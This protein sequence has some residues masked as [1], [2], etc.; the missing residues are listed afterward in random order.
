MKFNSREKKPKI[1]NIAVLS[2]IAV[3]VIAVLICQDSQENALKIAIILDIYY[4]AVVVLLIRAFVLQL[5]YNPYSYNSIYYMGFSFF[6]FSSFITHIYLT[7]QLSSP[8]NLFMGQNF[9]QILNI[10][11][12][13]ATNYILFTSPL[14]TIFAVILCVS[15][16]SLIHHEGRRLVNVLGII[17]SLFLLGGE[18][19]LFFRNDGVMGSAAEMMVHDL[20]INL[21]AGLYLYVECM[22]IGVTIAGTLVS[23]YT[24][25]YDKDFV[26]ILGC[27]IRKDGSPSPLLKGRVDRAIAFW[28]EQKKR[29]GKDLIFICSG[30]QGKNEVCSEASAM[31]NYMIAQG[32]PAEQILEE[33]KSTNTFQ[34]MKFS[35]KKVEEINPKAKVAFSTTN[36]HVFRSG[37]FA[38]RVGMRAVGMG[39]KTKWYFWPNAAVR[40][41][42]GLLTEHRG[43]Q[44]I[45]IGAIVAAYVL[46]TIGVYSVYF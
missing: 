21:L 45:I 28:Q 36:Y 3:I 12:S 4:A 15:N 9:E 37:L 13:S 43:K 30:G 24:P 26:I 23:K 33:D 32:V 46:L 19:I 42:I 38:R 25:D 35:K 20:I 1:W 34:N 44:A 5:R 6:V 10:L 14:I 39:A 7:V 29:S 27:G 31:K 22:I 8:A 41:F 18:V 11:Y 17:L 40:E 16:I 2:L